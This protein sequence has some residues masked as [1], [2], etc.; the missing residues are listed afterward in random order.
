MDLS[1]FQQAVELLRSAQHISVLTG[2]GVSAESGI[3]TF[4]ASDGLWEGHAIEEVATPQGYRRNPQLVWDFYHA[5]RE[6]AAQVQ[7][8]PGHVALAALEQHW[9]DR[10]DL[11]TQNVDGLHQRAGNLRVHELHGSLWRS[12][13]TECGDIAAIPADFPRT[14]TCKLCGGALRP[15]IVWFGEM[16]PGDVFRDA[17]FAAVECDLML[18]VGTSAVVYPAAGLIPLAKTSSRA[19]NV[20]AAHVIEINITPS[21]ASDHVDVGLYGP[22]GEILPQ[23]L[24]ALN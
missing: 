2:A 19:N 9:A 21:S 7:P 18:V 14:P 13:C 16:L 20:V 8:N 15:D 4:R 3:P 22:S 10:F 6:K 1:Q 5:R 23:L 17:E 11:I 24:A 12:R